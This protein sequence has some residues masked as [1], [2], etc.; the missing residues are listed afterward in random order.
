MSNGSILDANAYRPG[1]DAPDSLLARRQRVLG[2]ANRLFYRRP[3]EFVRGAGVFLYDADGKEYLDTYNNVAGLG[4][5]HPAVV[6]AVSRQ[7]GVL[8][9]HSRYLD[10]GLIAYAEQLTATMP[11]PVDQVMFTCTGSEAN[12]LALR[13]AFE[14]TGGTGVIITDE[15]YHGNTALVT[16]ISPSLG[17]GAPLGPDV[18]VVPAP[19]PLRRPSDDVG[20]QFAAEV[21]RVLAEMADNGVQPAALIVDTIL[22]SDGVHSDPP[23]FLTAAV[24]AVRAAGGVFIADEVQPGFARTG[25]AFWGF[26]RHGLLPDIVTLGKPMGNGMPIAAVAAQA[27]VLAPFATKVPYFNTFSG[28]QVCIAAA[29]AVLE[30]IQSAK[31]QQNALDVGEYFRAVLRQ[32]AAEYPVIADVRGDGLFVGVELVAESGTVEPGTEL[33]AD[34]ING[35]R[36]R[37]VL[38]SVCGR[39]GATLKVRP[40][41]IFELHHADR[42]ANELAMVLR[43]VAPN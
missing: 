6:E 5:A 39:Y 16:G 22:S 29:T 2:P 4:H 9:T 36:E 8:T 26:D 10:G 40:P 28:G 41:L 38:T 33:A 24:D 23:S 31:L 12:D 27:E 30:T 42:F 43:Q 1:G 7:V 18:W 3:V 17:D 21:Q 34:V 32:V 19:D 20:A 14:A 11:T 15:A 13:I 25:S 35:L 37:G